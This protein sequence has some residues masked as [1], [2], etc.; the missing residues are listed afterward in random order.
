MTETMYPEVSVLVVGGG[1]VGLLTAALL[2]H[3]GVPPVLVER[4]QRPSVH[5]RATGIGPR[6]VEI[7]RELGLDAA[8]DAVAVDLRGAAGKAVART[9]VEMGE[10]DVVTVPMPSRSD[11]ELAATPFSLRG[12]CA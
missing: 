5:P 4:R 1:S 7:L 8:V 6:T 10:G 12:V 9:V 3:H 11:G 2:A